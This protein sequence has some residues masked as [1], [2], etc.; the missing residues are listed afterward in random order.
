MHW[1]NES[2]RVSRV[3]NKRLDK[4]LSCR[5]LQCVP[6]LTFD[7]WVCSFECASVCSQTAAASLGWFLWLLHY[8]F[9]GR[10]CRPCL[11]IS[12]LFYGCTLH[13]SW[14]QS[15][16]DFILDGSSSHVSEK[17]PDELYISLILWKRDIERTRPHCARM[18]WARWCEW[19]Q[20]GRKCK[21]VCV[22]VCVWG[23][24]GE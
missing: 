21:G 19:A 17:E 4:W 15:V 8:V 2:R 10:N 5:I 23:R 18:A 14:L 20:S 3:G 24:V 6:Q 9:P 22:F 1:S 16:Y 13:G 12:M 7:W 11:C